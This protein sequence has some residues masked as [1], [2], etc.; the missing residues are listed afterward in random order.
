M[1]KA[2]LVLS[3]SGLLFGF[4]VIGAHADTESVTVPF[5][6]TLN[7]QS[8]CGTGSS[9]SF[10]E[11]NPSLGTLTSVTFVASGTA[12]D[13]AQNGAFSQVFFSPAKDFPGGILGSF[14]A[15]AGTFS[16]DQSNTSAAILAALTGTGDT[17]LTVADG[18]PSDIDSVSVSNAELIYTYTPATGAT[19]EPS[20]LALLGTGALGVAGAVR[21]RLMNR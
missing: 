2:I 21:R 14:G 19:P 18:A 8:C 17:T 1:K 6:G 4:G 7:F 3:V 9:E 20:G 12:S 5:S 16:I 10:A 13:Y 11:F 15:G